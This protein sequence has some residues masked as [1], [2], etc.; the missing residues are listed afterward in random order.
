[1]LRGYV[2]LVCKLWWRR[3]VSWNAD[4]CAF[5]WNQS[6]WRPASSSKT[7]QKKDA[8]I[9]T[10]GPCWQF[11]SAEEEEEEQQ[12]MRGI[13]A[14]RRKH[15]PLPAAPRLLCSNEQ[16]W[17]CKFQRVLRMRNPVETPRSN[18]ANQLSFLYT[19]NPV[20]IE[21]PSRCKQQ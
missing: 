21:I 2:Q 16:I 12:T 14:M 8:M 19:T 1:M 10:N 13:P 6:C 5:Q 15:L 17:I 4:G 9:R 18:Y 7:C 11:D 3:N 20:Q